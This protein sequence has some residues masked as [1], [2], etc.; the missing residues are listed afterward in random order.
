MFSF[1]HR[2]DYCWKCEFHTDVKIENCYHHDG[3]Q[4][5]FYK[6]IPIKTQSKKK[7]VFGLSSPEPPALTSGHRCQAPG[8][9]KV[10]TSLN[11]T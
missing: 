1:L 9:H 3:E 8:P 11:W 10:L 7:G 2:W 4:L 6:N 5:G